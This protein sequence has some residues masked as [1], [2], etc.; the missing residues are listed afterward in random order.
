MR[1][2]C[3]KNFILFDPIISL[4]GILDKSKTGKDVKVSS[5]F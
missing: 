3:L 1:I 5:Y 2:D 4:L